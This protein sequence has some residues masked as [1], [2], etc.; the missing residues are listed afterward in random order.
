MEVDLDA[1][2]KGMALAVPYIGHMGIEVTAMSEGEAT[3]LLPDRPELHNHV[4]SQHAGAL[5]GVAETASGAAF[6]GA[7]AAR[8]GDLTPLARSAEIAYSKV[9]RGPIEAKAKLGVPAA[10]ALAT[11]DADGR[12]DF[13]VEVEMTDAEGL[14]VATATVDWNVRLKDPE[15]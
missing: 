5:F 9:A 6:V 10:E 12:V 2:A 11:L 13:S 1:I 7:F 15:S 14:V 3:A 4:G 8:M